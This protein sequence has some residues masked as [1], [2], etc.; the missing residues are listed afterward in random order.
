MTRLRIFLVVC[1]LGNLLAFA[2]LW[3]VWD[4]FNSTILI[5]ALLLF[6]NAFLSHLND[7]AHSIIV[8]QQKIIMFQHAIITGETPRP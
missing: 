6:L 7:E 2:L 5:N 1:G 3:V 8:E 4:D